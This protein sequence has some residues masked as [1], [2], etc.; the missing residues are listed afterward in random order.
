MD[1][2][3]IPYSLMPGAAMVI[4]ETTTCAM[5][6]TA[7]L[8]ERERPAQPHRSAC[9]PKPAPSTPCSPTALTLERPSSLLS[10]SVTVTPLMIS[11]KGQGTGW[12]WGSATPGRCC[13]LQGTAWLSPGPRAL[14]EH[15]PKSH[16][17]P[18]HRGPTVTCRKALGPRHL[19][20]EPHMAT[21]TP[22]PPS[23]FDHSRATPLGCS[24]G[25]WGC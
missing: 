4:L 21:L 23:C 17:T 9:A 12:P 20:A 22:R 25:T 11:L 8:C 16:T 15:P 18:G 14:R 13:H 5:P 24:A 6:F 2:A 10:S 19:P 7:A 3:P 1:L